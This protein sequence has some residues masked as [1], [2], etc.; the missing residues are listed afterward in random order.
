MDQIAARASRVV[1]NGLEDVYQPH[2]SKKEPVEVDEL[3]ILPPSPFRLLD[4]YCYMDEVS[5]SFMELVSERIC[6]LRTL[7]M[8]IYRKAHLPALEAALR[9]PILSARLESLCLE[10]LGDE[11]KWLPR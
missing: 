6:S 5:P 8:R 2:S 11:R 9:M 4:Q 3:Q 10:Y 7:R 1:F